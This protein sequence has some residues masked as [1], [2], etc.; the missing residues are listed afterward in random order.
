[1]SEIV[2][3]A[4]KIVLLAFLYIFFLRV[5]RAVWIEVR[6]EQQA[7]AKGAAA[8]AAKPE[9]AAAA[10]Q[11]ERVAVGVAASEPG[12]RAQVRY[13]PE[14]T[15]VQS[16]V[17]LNATGGD[18]DSVSLGGGVTMGRRASCEVVLQDTYASQMHAKVYPRNGV[19]ILEDLGSTNGT[20][21]NQVRVTG[22]VSVNVG[23]RI[24]IG[25]TE[26]ELR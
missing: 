3:S 13:E 4:L 12:D 5:L 26:M 6:S 22:T 18:V 24:R 1:V 9:P 8:P 14:R 20:Y 15:P 10:P 25:N 11:R 7:A 2:L 17:L 19:W 21:V 16:L 23:D